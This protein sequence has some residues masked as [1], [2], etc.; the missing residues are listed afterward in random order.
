MPDEMP[1][2]FGPGLPKIVLL[3]PVPYQKLTTGLPRAAGWPSVATKA[4]P[5]KGNPWFERTATGDVKLKVNQ[6]KLTLRITEGTG[7]GVYVR[8]YRNE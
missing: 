5:W 4:C 6:L 3:E 1:R 7:M 8:A 2:Q